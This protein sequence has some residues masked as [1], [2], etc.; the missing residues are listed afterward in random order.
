MAKI[1]S[2]TNDYGKVRVYNK[3]KKAVVPDA[4]REHPVH[5]PYRRE[6][7]GVLRHSLMIDGLGEE[8]DLSG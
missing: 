6:N 3:V 1:E 5:A 4:E 7:R 8:D 2:D